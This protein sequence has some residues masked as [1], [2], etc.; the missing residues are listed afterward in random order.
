MSPPRLKPGVKLRH[1]PATGPMLMAPERIMTLDETAL[2][3]VSKIDGVRDASTI[4]QLLA[5]EFD[6]TVEDIA[7]DVEE[8]LD[9]LSAGGYIAR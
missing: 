1:D 9:Q 5:A 2:A 8:L 6:A 4:S 7:A 3:I